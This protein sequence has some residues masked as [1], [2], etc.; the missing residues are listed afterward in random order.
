MLPV[1]LFRS[2]AGEVER[3]IAPSLT[4][5]EIRGVTGTFRYFGYPSPDERVQAI[6]GYS[7]RVEREVDLSYRHLALFAN[8]FHVELRLLLERDAAVRFFGLGGAS[9]EEN[10]TNFTLETTGFRGRFGV[11]ITP[12]ARLSLGERVEWIDVRRGGVRDL[13]FIA[14]RFPNLPGLDGAV[15]H[16]QRVAFTFDTRDSLTTPTR[17]VAAG[18][19]LEASAEALGSAAD[20]VRIGGEGVSLNPAFDHRLVFVAHGLVEVLSGDDDTPFFVRPALG[21]E[22]TLRGFGAN[23][24][25][26]DGRLLLNL[27][28]RVRM[29]RLELFGVEA[30]FE[31]VP[32][33]D[34]GK[35]FTSVGAV[36]RGRLEV[37]P[38]LGFRALTR[39]NV[40]GRLDIGVRREGPAIFVGLDYPF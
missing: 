19:F 1:V 12:T 39:P 22:D 28:A 7:S 16:A 15:I 40:V 10:E 17:G 20:Y 18:A 30:E 37:T 29:L 36:H 25:F 26:G 13:P 21:G 38:G 14:E 8:R 27:E 33:V 34:L 31:G 9:R 6:L 32:F 11:N 3:I 35:V 24:F 2:P 4:F 5:N 23:R